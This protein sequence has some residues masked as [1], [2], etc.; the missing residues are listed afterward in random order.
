MRVIRT[1]EALERRQQAQYLFLDTMVDQGLNYRE[2]AEKLAKGNKKKA[3]AWRSRWRVWIQEPTFQEMLHA[4]TMGEMRSGLPE[5]TAALVRRAS[6]GNVP[7]IKLAME[8]SG[9]YNPR[10]EHHHSGKI[11]I[12][13]KG[14]TRPAITVDE[15]SV[16]DADVVEE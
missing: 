10:M 1:P 7:A 12:E 15:D 8:A 2:V 16:V 9:Y 14:V 4:I 6:K 5:L 11:E 13:L 3:K